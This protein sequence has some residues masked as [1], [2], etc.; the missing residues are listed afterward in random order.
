ML[1]GIGA[2]AQQQVGGGWD[3]GFPH[4]LLGEG[5]RP[6]K[7]GG[8]S[9]RTEGRHP[10]VLER[11]DETGDQRRLWPDHDEVDPAPLSRRPDRR[12]VRGADLR[13]AGGLGGDP[14]V[15]GRAEELGTFARARE[16]PYQRVLAPAPAHDQDP[17]ARPRVRRRADR[18][19][20][21]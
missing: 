1:L 17:Q 15:A 16:R 20:A 11:V 21:R 5:L 7:L 2:T 18:R 10:G 12:D 13:Q 19:G 9:A 3:A 8:G 4:Q 6:L 14:G